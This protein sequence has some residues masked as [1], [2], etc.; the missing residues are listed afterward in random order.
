MSNVA[1]PLAFGVAGVEFSG[2]DEPLSKNET[3]PAVTG[4]APESTVALI[5]TSDPVEPFWLTASVVVVGVAAGLTVR[6]RL[7]VDPLKLVGSVGV[8]VAVRLWEPAVVNVV[9][10]VATPLPL[11]AADPRSVVPSLKST[12][13]AAAGDSVA[14]SVSDWP[15]VAVAGFAVSVVVVAVTTAGNSMDQLPVVGL[16]RMSSSQ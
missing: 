3:V 1:T 7:P 15:T 4:V 11:T 9:A 13:P 12:E 16:T 5:E 2:V 14:V 6:D 8:N 10:I